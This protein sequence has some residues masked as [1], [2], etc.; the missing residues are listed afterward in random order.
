MKAMVLRE[1][2]SIEKKPLRMEDLPNPV[3]GPGEILVKVSV[4][5]VCHTEL[6][7]IEGRLKPKLPVILGHQVIG[8]VAGL[9]SGTK[10]FKLGDR[11]GIAWIYSA[12]GKCDF[13]VGGNENLCPDFKG[14]GC[15][16]NGGYAQYTAV[17]ENYAYCIPERF[18]DS[19]AAPLLCAGAI[20]Y[21]DLMLSNIKKGQVLGL[22]GFGASAHIVIQVARHWGCEVFVFTRGEEHQNLARRLGASWVGAPEDQPPQKLHCAVDFTPVGET[23][24]RALQLLEKGGRLVV[25][26][27]RKRNPIPPLDYSQ[28]LWDEKEIKS[29]ANITRKDAEDFL[30]LAAEIPIIP[31]VQEFQLADAN[32]ALILLKQ[33][34]IQGSGVLKIADQFIRT[35]GHL[36]M[37][38]MMTTKEFYEK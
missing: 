21:R 1:I 31:E 36:R 28:H 7:E 22:F 37:M 12:C 13:C 3:S 30:S 8:R 29:V 5:G 27:I 9:G 25:A 33:G 17:D 32:Q 24:P 14:T 11:V 4:C 18:S 6:D 35:R 38:E 19:Q 16:A 26:V 10:R 20:G 34:R 2:S 23:V 15:D